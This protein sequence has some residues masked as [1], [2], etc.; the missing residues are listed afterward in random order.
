[1]GIFGIGLSS[2]EHLDLVAEIKVDEHMLP[3]FSEMLT[4]E[5]RMFGTR[6]FLG[7]AQPNSELFSNKPAK[8]ELGGVTDSHYKDM[9][10]HRTHKLGTPKLATS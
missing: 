5:A 3:K 10:R 9:V 6:V 4:H 2:N 1:M 8:L 7:G